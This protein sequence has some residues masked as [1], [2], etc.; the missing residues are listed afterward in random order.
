ML[1][2]F[3]IS[4]V[5]SYETNKEPAKGANAYMQGSGQFT[6]RVNVDT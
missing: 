4:D 1:T 5:F 6:K 3:F 2:F